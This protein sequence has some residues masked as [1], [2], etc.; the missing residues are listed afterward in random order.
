MWAWLFFRPGVIG[1]IKNFPGVLEIDLRV[2]SRNF[3]LW[4]G[5]YH[6]MRE[7]YRIR[8]YCLAK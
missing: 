4:G 3:A 6:S 1:G 5:E 2:P 7:Y 8:W